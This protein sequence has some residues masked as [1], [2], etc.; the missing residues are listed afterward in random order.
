MDKEKR[1]Y[2]IF[3]SYNEISRAALVDS[4]S[5][6][7]LLQHVGAATTSQGPDKL[8][9]EVSMPGAVLLRALFC[10]KPPVDQFLPPG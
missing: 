5:S 4:A 2:G 8:S 3:H 10:P 9:S 7:Q 1:F 6:L